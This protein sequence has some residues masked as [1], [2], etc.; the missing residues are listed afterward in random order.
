MYQSILWKSFFLLDALTA[1][2]F[3]H[4]CNTFFSQCVE[5]SV[6]LE[7]PVW[8]GVKFISWKVTYQSMSTVRLTVKS[9]VI[10]FCKLHA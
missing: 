10:P 3:V 5:V 9:A 4:G 1:D 2:T 7:R 6:K 8:H